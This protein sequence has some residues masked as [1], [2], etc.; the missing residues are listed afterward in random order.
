MKNRIILNVTVN[1]PLWLDAVDFDALKV[2]EDLKNLT[3]E[4]MA[5]SEHELLSGDKSYYLNV[6]LSD[7]AEVH[8]L[9]KEFRG[10]D[11]PT[12][13]LSFANVDDDEFWAEY[14]E[15]NELELGDIILAYETLQ[16]EANI[17]G[18]SI[19]AHY[20]HLLVHG[21]L[22][23]LGFDHQDDAEAEEMEDIETDILAMYSIENPY[24][25]MED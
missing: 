1:N 14:E 12:N 9:N 24:K 15:S 6:C 21:F 25:E 23:L 3:F 5:N 20:G 8:Q 19:Y 7:D 2:A 16:N 4:Y 10:M 22:H 13:V 18:I 11:K 17:K